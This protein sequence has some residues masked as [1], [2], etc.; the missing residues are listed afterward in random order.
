MKLL[1]DQWEWC[2]T[3][4]GPGPQERWVILVLSHINIYTNFDRKVWRPSSKSV[5]ALRPTSTTFLLWASHNSPSEQQH[6]C[7]SHRSSKLN[8]GKKR[9]KS[10]GFRTRTS[11]PGGEWC[12]VDAPR[13]EG[14]SRNPRAG[15][16]MQSE[17]NT[18]AAQRLLDAHGLQA[19]P[20]ETGW[21]G[22]GLYPQRVGTP[23]MADNQSG[24]TLVFVIN[25]NWFLI[26]LQKQTAAQI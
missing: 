1:R 11:R 25:C 13:V 16:V 15:R 10:V 12:H 2:R 9:S 24:I 19:A 20:G 17:P 4:H 22:R 3:R 14:R 7:W 6:Q 21:S 5:R 18:A 8:L 26:W 23:W